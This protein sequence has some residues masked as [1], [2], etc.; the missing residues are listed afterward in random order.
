MAALPCIQRIVDA[1]RLTWSDVGHL[2]DCQFASFIHASQ[3]QEPSGD[4]HRHAKEMQVNP[5][6][7]FFPE[8]WTKIC[9]EYFM[10]NPGLVT[11]TRREGDEHTLRGLA[12]VYKCRIKIIVV[13]SNN[14]HTQTIPLDTLLL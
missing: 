8:A 12:G 4:Q 1:N 7:R 14:H 11:N 6:D 9:N 13:S 10:F 5:P 2:P 3:Q